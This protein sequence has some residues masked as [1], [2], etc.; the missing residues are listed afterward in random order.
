MSMNNAHFEHLA[1]Q[2][3]PNFKTLSSRIA[4]N[5]AVSPSSLLRVIFPGGGGFARLLAYSGR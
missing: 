5:F 3:K 2:K 4:V 1:V